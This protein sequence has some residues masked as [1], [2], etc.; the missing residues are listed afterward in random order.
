MTEYI[1]HL[2]G[3]KNQ[4]HRLALYFLQLC[5]NHLHRVCLFYQLKEWHEGINISEIFRIRM[6][7]QISL[8]FV[9]ILTHCSIHKH[10]VISNV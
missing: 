9:C 3:S 8:K 2:N 7:Q 4:K 1:W 6:R 5:C 10:F